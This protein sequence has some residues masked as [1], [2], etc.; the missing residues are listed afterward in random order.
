MIERG[1]LSRVL[2]DP[3]QVQRAFE[4]GPTGAEPT[5][6]GGES[7]F[8]EERAR[9]YRE[10]REQARQELEQELATV[11]AAL[12]QAL[13]QLARAQEELSRRLEDRLLELV[14]TAASRLLRREVEQGEPLVLRA[15]QEASA[16]L[17]ERVR[18]SVRVN[19]ADAPAVR[20]ALAEAVAGGRMEIVAD[21]AVSRGGSLVECE[22]G[23]VDA[24]IE[25]AEQAIREALVGEGAPP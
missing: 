3:P 24:T 23:R 6:G 14:A 20:E 13:E 7:P 12:V 19:P 15:I 9:G 10:G 4:A 25:R 18:L 17:P 11:R 8:A 21:A 22:A 5:P 1:Q 16:V 2:E